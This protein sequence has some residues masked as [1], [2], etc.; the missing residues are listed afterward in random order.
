MN[1]PTD[2]P[3][4][5]PF[6][7]SAISQSMAFPLLG[8]C[9]SCH[10]ALPMDVWRKRPAVSADTRRL[11][12]LET[13]VQERAELTIR[14]WS[15]DGRR[16]IANSL[17]VHK[18]AERGGSD[19]TL[20]AAIDAALAPA[21]TD[22]APAPQ[23]EPWEPLSI[24]ELEERIRAARFNNALHG[25]IDDTPEI[26]RMVELRNRMYGGLPEASPTPPAS[27]A[28]TPSLEQLAK[29]HAEPLF[30]SIYGD[31]KYHE[32]D[33]DHKA[34]QRKRKEFQDCFLTA[35][36]ASRER[37]KEEIEKVNREYQCVAE[38][39][40]KECVA[41]EETQGRLLAQHD[42]LR[43][44]LTAANA[45]IAYDTECIERIT[46][47]GLEL[48]A[49]LEAEQARW[50]DRIDG[51]LCKAAPDINIDGSGCDSGDPLDLTATEISIVLGHLADQLTASQA[52]EREAVTVLD[53]IDYHCIKVHS[54]GYRG[55]GGFEAF[56]TDPG[57]HYQEEQQRTVG[58]GDTPMKAIREGLK[59]E[60]FDVTKMQELREDIRDRL[61]ASDAKLVEAVAEVE[62]LKTRY[63]YIVTL[64]SE[65]TAGETEMDELERLR[66][67]VS[68][69]AAQLKEARELIIRRIDDPESVTMREVLAS[70][71]PASQP[72]P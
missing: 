30:M 59:A 43:A 16:L 12:W 9:S 5:C 54:V 61:T 55:R 69:L 41:H 14:R 29:K 62:R 1:T 40:N 33:A 71:T 50:Q 6:C 11:D 49:Q 35:L 21:S 46:K 27:A 4:P 48:E 53:A 10:I 63:E 37:D 17:L 8:D 60:G 51:L 65:A 18:F 64:Y 52:R 23:G 45:Q 36:Q 26:G 57:G 68:T 44:D 28:E 56:V 39:Y 20:R 58:R 19:E 70:L 7:G 31:T 32:G 66:V 47:H 72:Q 2:K 15:H 13:Q 3:L 24:D 38:L 42:Q 67:E 34:L 22:V 25:A